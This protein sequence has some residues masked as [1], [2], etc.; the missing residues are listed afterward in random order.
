M[1]V[2]LTCL[3]NILLG[4]IED[5]VLLGAP[6]SASPKQ[7]KQIAKVV[8]GRIINGYCNTDWL[9]RYALA[10]KTMNFRFLYRTMSVQVSIAGTGPVDNKD[11]KKIVNFNLSHIVKGHLDYSKKLMEVLEAVGVKIDKN[12]RKFKISESEEVDEVAELAE[13][14]LKV[15]V[16][17]NK[18]TS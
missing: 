1:S 9:L 18:E 15:E 4:I 7:W 2:S 12:A 17:E 10:Q 6:V 16:N 5:V 14:E 11:E 8:G 3:L 13:K